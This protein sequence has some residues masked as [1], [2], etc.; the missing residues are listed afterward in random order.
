VKIFRDSDD[1]LFW[2]LFIIFAL[3][4]TAILH[5]A[6]VLDTLGWGGSVI[7]TISYLAVGYVLKQWVKRGARM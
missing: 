4:A 6:G 3:G 1:A 2:K 7:L 5:E